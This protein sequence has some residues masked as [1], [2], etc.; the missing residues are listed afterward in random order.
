ME[1]LTSRNGVKDAVAASKNRQR[2]QVIELRQHRVDPVTTLR[3]YHPHLTFKAL[4]ELRD[5][6]QTLLDHENRIETG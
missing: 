5:R 3:Q 1:N 4:R 2:T 6:R